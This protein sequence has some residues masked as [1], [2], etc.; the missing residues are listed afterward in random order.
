MNEFEII[1]VAVCIDCAMLAA[2]G[3]LPEDETTVPCSRVPEGFTLIVGDDEAF[4]S[5]RACDTCDSHLGGDRIDS[6]L[7][8][9]E[10]VSSG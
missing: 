1:E 4:V 2:N 9:N 5:W 3:E 10:R 6:V 8:S 7:M